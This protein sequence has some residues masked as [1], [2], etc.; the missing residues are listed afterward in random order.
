MRN[1]QSGMSSLTILVIMLAGAF[2]LLAVF[3]VGPLYLD[4]Y[5]VQSSVKALQDEDISKMTDAQV[6]K[7]LDR[8]FLINGVRDMSARDA[9]IERN[10]TSTV[11][12]LDYEKRIDFL[13]NLD[14]V[15]T[16]ENHFDTSKP[17]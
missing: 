7:V 1:N 11:V 2:V 10:K 6:R 17:Q 15:V 9:E 16:F 12:K 13:G 4:N 3:R 8:Y 5:F 14:V